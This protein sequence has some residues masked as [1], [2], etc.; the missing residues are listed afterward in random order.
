MGLS[1]PQFVPPQ[2]HTQHM[3]QHTPQHNPQHNPQLHP[4]Q[5][6]VQRKQ[7]SAVH[8]VGRCLPRAPSGAFARREGG[9]RRVHPMPPSVRSLPPSNVSATV[10]ESSLGIS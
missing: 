9:L 5:R 1:P 7:P 10:C 3:P 8:A 4:Q 2:E 6:P